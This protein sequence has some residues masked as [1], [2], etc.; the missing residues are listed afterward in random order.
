[1]YEYPIF[2]ALDINNTPG[3]D[4][5]AGMQADL[6]QLP[7]ANIK[8]EETL[9][10]NLG[11]DVGFFDNR[12]SFEGDIYHKSSYDLIAQLA[13]PRTSPAPNGYFNVGEVETRG[14]EVQLTS[15]NIDN[16]DFSWVTNLNI[17]RDQNK[18]VDL[19]TFEGL[20]LQGNLINALI[21][22]QPINVFYG[23]EANGLFLEQSELDELNTVLPDGTPHYYQTP[24]T[25]LGDIKFLDNTGPVTDDDGNILMD[26]NG[27]PYYK[28]D[29]NDK[30]IIG[31]P[32]PDFYFGMNNT[33]TIK[34]FDI[35]IFIQ[36]VQGIDIYHQTRVKGTNYDLWTNQLT[37][38]LDRYPYGT[39]VPRAD[40]L[41]SNANSRTS[42]RFV[43]DGSYVRLKNISFG[44]DFSAGWLQSLNIT[45]ARLY[46]SAENL[47]TLTN[48][49]GL[50]PEMVGG[51]GIE[52]GGYPQYRTFIIGLNLG[53]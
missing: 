12:L 8:W 26:Q 10:Y 31:D 7:N 53:F 39:E 19:G 5:I 4:V 29:E 15:Y 42:D 36:G 1:S 50:D 35:S 13:L 11:L 49:T 52:N 37:E 47:Y 25:T 48:F 21:D 45:K 16:P 44:Y 27:E 14:F 33:F 6:D 18:V 20:Q 32:N 46:A 3:P 43:E 34:N 38:V 22:G 28:I 51:N 40:P 23:Y 17:S 2:G 41:F 30:V 9:E 24:Y